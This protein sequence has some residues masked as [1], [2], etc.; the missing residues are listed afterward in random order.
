[1]SKQLLNEN[2]FPLTNDG[3]VEVNEGH[4]SFFPF[5]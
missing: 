5:F 2:D 1:M 3:G 4:S